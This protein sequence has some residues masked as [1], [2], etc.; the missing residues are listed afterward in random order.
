D[1]RLLLPTTDRLP[2]QITFV[3]PRYLSAPAGGFKVVY[4]YANHLQ[5]RGHRVAVVHPR[6]LSP[7]PGLMQAIKSYFWPYK[8]HWRDNRPVPWFPIHERVAVLLVPDLRESFIPDAD[9]IFATGYQTAYPVDAYGKRKGRKYYLIQHHETWDG[10]EADVNRTWVLPLH[11]IVIARW[12]LH[13]AND[14]GEGDRVTY[15]PNGI[16]FTHFKTT[17]PISD[18]PPHRIAMMSHPFAWKG[19]QDG[20]AALEMAREEIPE[21]EAVLF[22]IHPRPTGAPHWIRYV[23]QPSTLDLTALY[24]SCSI[25]LHTSWTEGWGLPSAEAM[26]C[27]CA[28]VAAANRGVLD[29]AKHEVTA[30]LAPIKQPALLAEQLLRAARDHPL[31]RRIAE[32]GTRHIQQYSWK[33]AVD[34]LEGL[35]LSHSE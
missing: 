6:N 26:S 27:G 10:S 35:L 3:L 4:E 29:F 34:S 20:L 16:D 21:L 14:F 1:Y 17:T 7:K 30:L 15:I 28:L 13:L 8:I 18:R 31:R 32:A 12:L 24:N 5:A 11:K 2:M 19:T 23:Q 33:R 25:F 22:G 9:V